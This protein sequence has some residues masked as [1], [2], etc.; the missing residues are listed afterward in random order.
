M[1]KI[2]TTTKR[3][4]ITV[5]KDAVAQRRAQVLSAA[6][7]FLTEASGPVKQADIYRAVLTKC[8]LE[9]KPTVWNDLCLALGAV[10]QK[11]KEDKKRALY[12]KV[13]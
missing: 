6:Q 7:E 10:A 11:A 2:E 1:S 4:Y 5:G 9:D 12:T 13:S 8:G 3:K